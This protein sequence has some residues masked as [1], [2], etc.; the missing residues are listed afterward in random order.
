MM[1][2][3]AYI[4]SLEGMESRCVPSRVPVLFDLDTGMAPW[5]AFDGPRWGLPAVDGV[6]YQAGQID[7]RAGHALFP[8]L[9]DPEG[10]GTI[11]AEI[12]ARECVSL[13]VTPLVISV[14]VGTQANFDSNAIGAAESLVAA[15]QVAHPE[16]RCLVSLPAGIGVISL[17]ELRGRNALARAGVPL[18]QAAGNNGLD[19]SRR[20]FGLPTTPGSVVISAMRMNGTPEPYTNR[21][22][23]AVPVVIPDDSLGTSGATMI[24]AARIAAGWPLPV[25]SRPGPILALRHPK[26]FGWDGSG[27]LTAVRGRVWG[28]SQEP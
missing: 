1:S 19:L 21:G 8:G 23:I 18:V 15:V 20:S 5:P 9:N 13:G 26:R 6:R 14:V 25:P 10:H 27:L 7:L 24:E 3:R 22:G 12:Y 17:A 28:G 11:M 2:R 16:V 4:P